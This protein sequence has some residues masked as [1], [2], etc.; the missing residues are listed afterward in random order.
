MVCHYVNSDTIG[1]DI[2]VDVFLFKL[3]TQLSTGMD[4]KFLRKIPLV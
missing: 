1:S 2:P 3:G 4:V